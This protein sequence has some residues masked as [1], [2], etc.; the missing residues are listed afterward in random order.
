M[1]FFTRQFLFLHLVI[2]ASAFAWIHGGTRPDLLLAVIPWLAGFTLEALLVF[3]QAKSTESLMEAR[4]RVWRGLVRDPLLYLSLLLILCLVIPLFNVAGYPTYN[5]ETKT[6]L[7]AIPPIS[8]LPFCVNPSEHASLLLWFPPALIAA[9]A[10][11]HGLLKKSKRLLLECLCWNGALLALL[12]FLQLA[13]DAKSIFWG[14]Q[15]FSHFFSTFGYP[16]FAGAFFTLLFALSTGLWFS[17]LG[18]HWMGP[19]AAVNHETSVFDERTIFESNYLL[20]AVLLNFAGAFASLSRAAIL[21]CGVAALVLSAY[22]VIAAWQKTMSGGHMVILTIL[23]GALFIMGLTLTVFAPKAL[24]H[25]VATITPKAVV[26]RVT[27]SAYYHGRIAREIFNDHPVFGVGGWGYPHYLVQY[28]T[29][30]ETKRMQIEGGAN[31]H[32]DSL[33]FLA[34]QGMVG[35]GL[36]LLCASALIFP[37]LWKTLAM[38]RELAKAEPS[39]GGQAKPRW[40]YRLPPEII[41]IVVGTTATVCHSMGD[42]P[43]RNPAILTVWVLA[44][45]CATGFLPKLRRKSE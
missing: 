45:S 5:P 26:E 21:L 31:V 28:L 13:T 25:E 12:G 24:K 37:L 41:A 11:K 14:D 23:F 43:F 10:A 44:W 35:Y 30:E 1:T 15:P 40:I 38:S 18:E 42:L 17:R 36:L 16:N 22:I 32:N 29:P 4:R 33:Q 20:A 3:P 34:E 6:W 9:L 7:N 8:F 2:L 27:G 39:H 19:A